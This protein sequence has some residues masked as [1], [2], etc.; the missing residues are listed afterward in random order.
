MTYYKKG[1][2]FLI[3][4]AIIA[5]PMYL[6]H[7]YQG[8]I[9]YYTKITKEPSNTEDALDDRG[10]KQGSIYTYSLS[11]VDDKGNE[12]DITF[13]AYKD[14]PLKENAY[15]KIKVNDIKGVLNWEEVQKENIPIKAKEKLN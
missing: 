11:S 12:K 9:Y 3:L 2:T 13:D 4:I 14:K 8:G 6:Y 5:T 15:L 1:I 10:I 7:K